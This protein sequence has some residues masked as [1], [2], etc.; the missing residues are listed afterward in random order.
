MAN[1]TAKELAIELDDALRINRTTLDRIAA[2]LNAINLAHSSGDHTLIRE[3]AEAA[4][5]LAEDQSA[6]NE[7]G[8]DQLR[9]VTA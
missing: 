6:M 9:G 2:I 7:T 5:Y 1:K 8:R 3:L 4:C